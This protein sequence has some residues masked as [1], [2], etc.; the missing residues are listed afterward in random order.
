MRKLL[1]FLV[2]IM[3]L[4]VSAQ[5]NLTRA[6]YIEKYKQI[7]IDEMNRTGVPASISLAQGILESGD[8][9][10]TLAR[11]ANNHFGI[12]CH[13]WQGETIY[14]DDDRPNEC[15]RS[16][17]NANESY[18]DHSDFLT[19]HQRYAFL[20]DYS[21]TDYK[22]WANGLKKAGYATS[23][24]YATM[25][26]KII[27]ENKLYEY[28]KPNKALAKAE[29][30]KTNGVKDKDASKT[31]KK[32]KSKRGKKSQETSAITYA[33]LAPDEA[34]VAPFGDV[35]TE[36]NVDYVLVHRG[37][38]MKSIS[39]HYGIL[40]AQIYRYNDLPKNTPINEG[41]RLYIQAK[42]SKASAQYSTHTVAEG[43]TMLSISQ[44]YAIKLKSL[45]KM[46]GMEQGTQPSVG[47]VIKLRK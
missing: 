30:D 12:K 41:E 13:G 20:F 39:E 25:L 15:F 47:D 3:A 1:T 45:Y 26:I 27:E 35:R 7:A 24:T 2:A 36:N 29:T 43:E 11:N 44:R 37:D 16:Y 5:K 40:A 31:D 33:E 9:N 42:K 19:S 38:D 17:K 6:E 21:T 34:E 22:K 14:H 8:G 23:N 4:Q 32:S 46:N 18:V 28:D 10:S